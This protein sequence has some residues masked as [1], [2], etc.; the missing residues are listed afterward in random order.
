VARKGKH[1]ER[2]AGNATGPATHGAA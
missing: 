2:V 1:D